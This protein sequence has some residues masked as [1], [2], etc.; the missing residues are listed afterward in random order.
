MPKVRASSATIGTMRGPSVGSLSRLPSRRTKAIV[1]DISL[2]AG[3]S[4]KRRVRRRAAAPRTGGAAVRRAG[5]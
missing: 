2:P 3:S 1:V 5:R 4:A